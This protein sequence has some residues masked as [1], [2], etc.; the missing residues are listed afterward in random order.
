MDLRVFDLFK[1]GI[2]SSS[3]HTVGPMK[4]ARDFGVWLACE[5]PDA[6]V[7][8]VRA[9]LFG[10]LALTG[11]GHGTDRAILLGL[12]GEIPEE[13]DSHSIAEKIETI[14]STKTLALAAN[15]EIPFD[16][17]PCLNFT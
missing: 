9:D 15:N 14:R 4:A 5:F 13:I 17:S 12:S 16:E 10:S 7:A 2:G 11:R 6:Q 3:S 8:R 1:T